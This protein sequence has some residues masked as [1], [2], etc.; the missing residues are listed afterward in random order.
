MHVYKYL[1]VSVYTSLSSISLRIAWVLVKQNGGGIQL[2]QTHAVTNNTGIISYKNKQ[3]ISCRVLCQRYSVLS[4][5]CKF[6]IILIINGR[7]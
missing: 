5:L 4:Q 1:Y 2:L 6:S 3:H 7:Y